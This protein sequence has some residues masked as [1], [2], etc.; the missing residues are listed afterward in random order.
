MSAS[1]PSPTQSLPLSWGV[2]LAAICLFA[3]AGGAIVWSQRADDDPLARLANETSNTRPVIQRTRPQP[4]PGTID[5]KDN[6]LFSVSYSIENG[7]QVVKIKLI[8]SGDE[9][10]VDAATGRLLE[11]RPSRP[12]APPAIGRFA[13]PLTPIT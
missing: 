3:I 4:P 11:T 10:V 1:S 9:M 6:R 8:E 5:A 13:V 2:A 7:T 12:S